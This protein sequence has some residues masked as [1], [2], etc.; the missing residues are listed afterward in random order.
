MHFGSLF[1]DSC[2]SCLLGKSGHFYI[3]QTSWLS[4]ICT[5]A[6]LNAEA[7]SVREHWHIL[8]VVPGQLQDSA[9][10]LVGCLSC[11]S[12]WQL[13]EVS[14]FPCSST[15]NRS[16][17]GQH[18]IL[19]FHCANRNLSIM[20]HFWPYRSALENFF[21]YCCFPCTALLINGLKLEQA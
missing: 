12:T 6:L 4:G 3:F 21:S 9:A 1:D 2:D 17:T 14:I 13:K 18:A 10:M 20:S 16:N 7:S 15:V 19:T 11:I 8:E 5:A